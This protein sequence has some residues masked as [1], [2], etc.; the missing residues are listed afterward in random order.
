MTF[1]FLPAV[2]EEL[3]SCKAALLQL[4]E[5]TKTKSG[6]LAVR[7]VKMV[8]QEVQAKLLELRRNIL[9]EQR[10]RLIDTNQSL[11]SELV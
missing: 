3:Q 7:N 6:E 2:K 10:D 1:Q 4:Q 11:T 5:E 9:R 8:D